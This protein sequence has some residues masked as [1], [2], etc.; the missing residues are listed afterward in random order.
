[1]RGK[2]G[3][4][5]GE[6]AGDGRRRRAARL[7]LGG[8]LCALVGALALC[9]GPAQ[10]ALVHD[11]TSQLTERPGEPLSPLLCGVNV[12]PAS[13]EV[14]VADPGA[15]VKEEEK[16]AIDVFSSAGAFVGK[17]DKGAGL[18]W[19]FREACS[20]AVNDTNG[21]IYVANNGEGEGEEEA[22]KAAVFV[23]TQE[24]GKF[25]FQK[26]LTLDGSNTPAGTFMV[27]TP[28]GTFEAG[29]STSRSPRLARPSMP[30]SANS[31]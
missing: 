15:E 7:G 12:D 24:A 27:P 25:K 11:Y 30:P 6:R 17:I 8:A 13:G 2:G 19:V 29:R 26:A 28:Q 4:R 3:Q 31:I 20:T 1:L 21:H 9:A 23:Y 18:E 5:C 16:P 10:A 14:Y 22:E